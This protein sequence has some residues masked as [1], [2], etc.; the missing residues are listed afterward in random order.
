VKRVLYSTIA[1]LALSGGVL[2]QSY[3]DKLAYNDQAFAKVRKVDILCNL[4]PVLYTRAQLNALL[5][6]IEEARK[7]VRKGREN[8]Y[9]V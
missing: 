4:L 8:E 5:T 3:D 7:N 2:A 1:L 9:T 6:A